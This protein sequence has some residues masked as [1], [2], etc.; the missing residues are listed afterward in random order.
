MKIKTTKNI[1]CIDK[2]VTLDVFTNESGKQYCL[3]S[4]G[5]HYITEEDFDDPE[6]NFFTIIEE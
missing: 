3:C 1:I 4:K 5:N 6:F 2:D